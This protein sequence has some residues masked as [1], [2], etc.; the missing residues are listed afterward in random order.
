MSL[1]GLFERSLRDE[2]LRVV[3]EV[4]SAS[5]AE[6][7]VSVRKWSDPYPA[8]GWRAG[9]A[10][11]FVVLL[12]LLFLPQPFAVETMPVDVALGFL[13]GWGS[14][15]L[16]PPLRAWFAGRREMDD[17]VRLAALAQMFEGGVT[18][19]RGG[20][21]VLVY[22][23]ALEKRAEIVLD[24]GLAGARGDRD[25][26]AAAAEV[27]AAVRV[28]DSARFVAALRALGPVLAKHAPRG[29]HDENELPDEVDA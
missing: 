10:L 7:V 26:L 21:G 20:T 25:L 11:A 23:S 14:A 18:G 5:R 8:A 28:Y 29:A 12:L 3:T 24:E 2:V 17:A 13:V 22:V 15:R 16:A 19:T 6:L 4:E 1:R 9:A 27:D